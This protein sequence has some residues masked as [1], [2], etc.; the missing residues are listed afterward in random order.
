MT[1][2]VLRPDNSNWAG[3]RCP[4]HCVGSFLE[5]KLKPKLETRTGA[6]PL[7]DVRRLFSYLSVVLIY[8]L[9]CVPVR[10]HFSPHFA[11]WAS[12]FQH[13]LLRFNK[14]SSDLCKVLSFIQVLSS[15]WCWR[16][17]IHMLRY[18]YG[19]GTLANT[20]GSVGWPMVDGW[21][22]AWSL[23]RVS[24]W[25]GM[26]HRLLHSVRIYGSWQRQ[27]V[28]FISRLLTHVICVWKIQ[29]CCEK[30]LHNY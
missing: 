24:F 11:V 13:F 1:V 29:Y 14:F 8:I 23:G 22:A 6:R 5:L 15:C 12:C 16:R 20:G 26:A 2:T 17:L 25:L 28:I 4:S 27:G 10:A 21:L 30:Y 9:D 7:R 19:L 3:C 18:R